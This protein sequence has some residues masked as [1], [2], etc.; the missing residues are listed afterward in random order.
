MTGPPLVFHATHEELSPLICFL[1]LW[2]LLLQDQ[3]D[4]GGGALKK[5][6]LMDGEGCFYFMHS[7]NFWEV[8]H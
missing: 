5:K 6:R 2:L 7:E 8:V 3:R 1:S 4:F